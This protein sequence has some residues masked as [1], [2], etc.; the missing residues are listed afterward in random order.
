[1]GTGLDVREVPLVSIRRNPGNRVVRVTDPD[2]IEL[3]ESIRAEG[4][5]QPVKIRP[6]AADGPVL[7]EMVFGERRMVGCVVAGLETIT[8]IVE[9]MSAERAATLTA[10]ENLQRKDPTPIQSAMS[11][12]QLFDLGWTAE[13]IGQHLGKP[14]RW[15][16]RRA[17]LTKLSETW[18]DLVTDPKQGVSRWSSSHLELIAR[19]PENVQEELAEEFECAHETNAR[20]VARIGL[21]DLRSTI[22]RKCMAL[23][24]ALWKTTDAELVVEAGSCDACRKRSDCQADLF[25]EGEFESAGQGGGKKKKSTSGARCLDAGCWQLKLRAHVKSQEAK[26]RAEHGSV[27][28]VRDNYYER[29]EIK[30]EFGATRPIYD[31]EQCKKSDSGAKPALIV[32]GSQAGRKLWVRPPDRS[33][34]GS[35]SGGSLGT[36]KGKSGKPLAERMVEYDWRRLRLII[37]DLA[38]EAGTL[39]KDTTQQPPQHLTDRMLLSLTAAFGT[40]DKAT[41][42]YNEYNSQADFGRVWKEYEGFCEPGAN[43]HWILFRQACGVI[44]DNLRCLG[45]LPGRSVGGVKGLNEKRLA[46]ER[47]AGLLGVNW[48]VMWAEAC[49]KVK[50]PKSWAAEA[51]K[52]LNA[53]P[54]SRKASQGK[55]K[56]GK[57][58]K[59]KKDLTTEDTESESGN[60]ESGKVEFADVSGWAYREPGYEESDLILLVESGLGGD[61]FMTMRREVGGVSGHRVKSKNLAP[62]ST[63]NEA[64]AD[65]DAYAKK[66]GL[67]RCCRL[68]GCIDDE[69]CDGGCSWVAPGVCSSH[70]EGGLDE[71]PFGDDVEEEE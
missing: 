55:G 69:A 7:F 13:V 68:C 24:G 47:L 58:K 3:A 62:R 26:L 42:L 33:G 56:K 44:E 60:Q 10:L 51:E 27:V 49:E 66:K 41:G 15:V 39:N 11:I 38:D 21:D 71:A 67:V 64:Q 4:L 32:E 35:G 40:R 23:D 61:T 25:D 17:Q 65:L 28:L 43:L 54:A 34:G 18:R 1:M 16:S 63:R 52:L 59:G 36:D 29:E 19:M 8:A 9:E 48:V 50:Y 5:Q 46:C 2:V 45:S 22:G 70:V 12:Q 57:A 20:A 6:V 31:L 30:K 37:A 53:A 14:A